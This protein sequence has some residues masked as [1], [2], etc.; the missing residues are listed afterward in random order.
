MPTLGN[1][2]SNP[3]IRTFKTVAAFEFGP[4]FEKI[5]LSSICHVSEP[6]IGVAARSRT[7]RKK[8]LNARKGAGNGD[9]VAF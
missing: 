9:L 8:N 1:W 7:S 2:H 6:V 3:I 5:N 4:R